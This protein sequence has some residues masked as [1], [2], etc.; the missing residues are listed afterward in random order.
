MLLLVAADNGDREIYRYYLV[1]LRL[2]VLFDHADYTSI[3]LLDI[4]MLYSYCTSL[5]Y[6]RAGYGWVSI[7]QSD[8][9]AFSGVSIRD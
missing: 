3:L 9:S 4:C 8:D 6:Q 2:C 7:A 5:M 1:E